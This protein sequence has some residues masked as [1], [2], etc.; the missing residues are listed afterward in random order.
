MTDYALL[1]ITD[2]ARDE[3]SRTLASLWEMWRGPE[4]TMVVVDDSGDPDYNDFVHHALRR[5]NAHSRKSEI[6]SI[7]S[8][9]E[10]TQGCPLAAPL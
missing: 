2:G 3:F 9:P 4:P 10:L 8:S 7:L 1:L 6:V 5:A